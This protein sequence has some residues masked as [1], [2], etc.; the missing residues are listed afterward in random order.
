MFKDLIRRILRR[1]ES[2]KGNPVSRCPKC[3]KHI[4]YHNGHTKAKHFQEC[5]PEYRFKV[6][7]VHR[8]LLKDVSRYTCLV[9]NKRFGNFQSLVERH[10]H[11]DL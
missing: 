9:C 10:R 8:D 4:F 3:G 7:R 6:E 1:P 5:H 2:K 11:A